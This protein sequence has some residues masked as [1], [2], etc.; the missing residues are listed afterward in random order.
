MAETNSEAARGVT[1]GKLGSVFVLLTGLSYA[2]GYM[3][4]FMASQRLGINDTGGE[5]LKC[6]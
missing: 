2:S 6:K 3:V 4:I 1:I 5:I